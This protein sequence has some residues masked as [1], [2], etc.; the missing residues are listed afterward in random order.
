MVAPGATSGDKKIA[1]IRAMM[2]IRK[3]ISKNIKT[4]LQE[5]SMTMEALAFEADINKGNLSRI[6]SCNQGASLAMIAKI[7]KALNVDVELIFKK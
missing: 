3:R 7:A 1:N 2:N 4:L 6:L 5:R